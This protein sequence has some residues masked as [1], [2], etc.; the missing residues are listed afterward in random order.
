MT[1]HTG[2]TVP[3]ATNGGVETVGP[4]D[5][6]PFAVALDAVDTALREHRGSTSHFCVTIH[7]RPFRSPTTVPVTFDAT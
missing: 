6:Y 4:R 3:P 1:R 7:G 5:P 2:K